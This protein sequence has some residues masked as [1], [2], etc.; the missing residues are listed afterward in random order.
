MSSLNQVNLIGR[1]G[2]D[3]EVRATSAGARIANVSLATSESW[4]DKTSGEKKEDTEWHRLVMFD[5]L[6]E[7]CEQYVRKGAMIYVSGRLKTR[8]WTDKDGGEKYTTEVQVS[9]LELLVRAADG[10]QASA[11][12][13]RAAV[14]RAPAGAA[15]DDDIPF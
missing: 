12:A 5:R 13:P 8:K 9:K 14:A 11:A 10:G 4:K 7:V 15:A 6:A 2:R 1:V 3:P